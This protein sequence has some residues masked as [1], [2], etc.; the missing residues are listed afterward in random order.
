MVT[1]IDVPCTTT[2]APGNGIPS[3][4]ETTPDTVFCAKPISPVIKSNKEKRFT[5]FFIYYIILVEVVNM[6]KFC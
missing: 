6:L 2:V 3:V 4:S 5:N 1:P